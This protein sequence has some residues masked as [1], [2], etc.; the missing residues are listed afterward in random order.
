MVPINDLTARFEGYGA[1][2][3]VVLTYALVTLVA[4]LA[5]CFFAF[6]MLAAGFVLYLCIYAFVIPVT[7]HTIPLVFDYAPPIAPLAAPSFTG[8]VAWAPLMSALNPRAPATPALTPESYARG[9]AVLPFS[10]PPAPPASAAAAAAARAATGRPTRAAALAL[11]QQ[12]L[13]LANAAAA[14]R[15]APGLLSTIFAR[16]GDPAIAAPAGTVSGVGYESLALTDQPGFGGAGVAGAAGALT[17]SWSYR[18]VD[19]AAN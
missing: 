10:P 13:L 18:Y 9:A 4:F 5:F 17:E 6:A 1:T 2:L 15:A 11:A 12:T 16:G 14:S 7:A 19:Q 3:K 8:P